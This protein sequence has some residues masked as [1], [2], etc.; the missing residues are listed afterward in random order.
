MRMGTD[1]G[2]LGVLGLMA[3][4]VAIVARQLLPRMVA[5]GRRAAGLD[6]ATGC[7]TTANFRQVANVELRRATRG[8]GEASLVLVHFADMASESA[9]VLHSFPL[10]AGAWDPHT[11]AV[12][13]GMAPDQL[14]SLVRDRLRGHAVQ[15]VCSDPV[16][17][18]AV[19][20]RERVA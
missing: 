9:E 19:V 7:L 15:V 1:T 10:V 2:M 4:G 13:G 16:S 3:C 20:Q 5:R 14:M 11:V 12:A 17:I 8:G 6:S 18:A